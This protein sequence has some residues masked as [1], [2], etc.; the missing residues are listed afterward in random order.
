M[1]SAIA[2]HVVV[3]GEGPLLS[4]QSVA[5]DGGV[6]LLRA[7]RRSA[8]TRSPSTPRTAITPMSS[9]TSRLLTAIGSSASISSL[10]SPISPRQPA[11]S[12]SM[13]SDALLHAVEPAVERVDDAAVDDAGA[14]DDPEREGEEDRD[15]RHEVEPEVDHQPEKT[16]F[17]VTQRPAH[18]H[19]DGLGDDADDEHGEDGGP[20]EQHDVEA[21]HPALVEPAHALGVDE[22]GAEAQ[23]GEERRRHAPAGPCRGTRPSWRGSRRRR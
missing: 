18:E 14:D 16:S 12:L 4:S 6:A 2:V 22:H 11:F 19:V 13:R 17:S 8:S 3:V 21:A 20:D 15:E 5:G 7:R 1:A 9:S 10:S 23:P